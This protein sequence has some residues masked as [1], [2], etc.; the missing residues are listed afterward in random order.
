M[1]I[2]HV[3]ASADSRDGGPIEHAV[4]TGH[5]FALRGH[6]QDFLTFDHAS[7]S[8][9]TD[10][11]AHVFTFARRPRSGWLG[12]FASVI[13]DL[14][15]A[16][17]WMRRRLA[18]YDVVVVS[19]LWNVA[20]LAARLGLPRGRTPYIVFIH[21]MLDPYFKRA[22]PLKSFMKQLLWLV[23]ERVLVRHADRVLFTCEEERRLARRSYWPY[24]AREQVVAFGTADVPIPSQTQLAAFADHV[25]GLGDRPFLLFLS[26]IHEKK[27]VDLLIRG[28]AAWL[29][30]NP[31]TSFDLVIAGPDNNGLRDRLKELARQEG[32]DSRIHW[33]GMLKGHAKWGAFRRCDAFILPSHQENFGIVIA[34][35]LA[36]ARPVLISD[37]VNIWREVADDG[38]GLVETDS[39]EGVTTLLQ[40][41]T[42]LSD[43]QRR[44]MEDA[45]RATFSRRYDLNSAVKDLEH[46]MLETIQERGKVTDKIKMEVVAQ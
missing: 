45:A 40:R 26:R 9:A 19:G 39:V 11:N 44:L 24:S 15:L 2:L 30:L 29:R 20:T 17:G 12:K 31:G 34:E 3:I 4:R 10:L 6:S 38:A 41:W 5:A 23:N 13:L 28:Y 14:P 35:A 22:N 43:D 27:G 32:V 33:P 36:C 25:P 46:I 37:K 1:R 16:L 7:M 42:S 21:G 8:S 18:D